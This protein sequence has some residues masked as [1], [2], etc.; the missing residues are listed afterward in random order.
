MPCPLPLI[1][2]LAII[3]AGFFL[4][5]IGAAIKARQRPVVS[6]QEEMLRCTGEALED[7]QDGQAV[8]GCTARPGAHGAAK[9]V[10]RGDRLRVIAIDGLT[11]EVA[12][13]QRGGLIWRIPGI[14]G[15]SGGWSLRCCFTR[16][17][18]CAS[19]SAA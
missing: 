1:L 15:A 18:C 10:Q 19:T 6:G 7:F 16:F 13:H 17:G 3:S 12:A 9:P 14:F 5:I 8:F 2:A 11:L 4:L